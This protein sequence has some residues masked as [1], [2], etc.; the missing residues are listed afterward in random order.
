MARAFYGVL[1][2]LLLSVVLLK[3]AEGRN[4]TRCGLTNEL[5]NLGFDRTLLGNWVCLVESESGKK[6][7]KMKKKANGSY[8]LGLFQINSKEWCTFDKKGGKC[9]MKCEDLTNDDI[10]DD[11]RCAQK[12]FQEMGFRGW[13]GWM[14][15]C[16]GRKLPIPNC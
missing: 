13:E 14:R 3:N 15:S 7:D 10:S 11:S 8:A 12:A 6:T 1:C 2:F 9:D 4:L 5:M 16:Y